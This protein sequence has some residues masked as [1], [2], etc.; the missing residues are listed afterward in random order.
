[1]ISEDNDE[2]T[3]SYMMITADG[4]FYQNTEGQYTKSQ[5]ILGVGMQT[6][7]EQVGFDY[8]KFKKRGG[9]YEL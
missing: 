9:A 3:S 2:M 5:P 6:A 8:G 7:L 4:R 1:M